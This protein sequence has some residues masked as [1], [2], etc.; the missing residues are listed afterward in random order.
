MNTKS[1]AEQTGILVLGRA[2]AMLAEAVTPLLIV[3]LLGKADVGALAGLMLIYHTLTVVLTAGFPPAVL[4]FLADR[5]A[6]TRRWIIGRM[7]IVLVGLGA[8]SSLLLIAIGTWGD[9]ALS[10]FGSWLVRGEADSTPSTV[11]LSYLVYFALFP[12]FDIPARILSNLF[13]GEGRPRSAAGYGVSQ[14]LGMSIGIGLPAAL[15]HGLKGIIF[16]L[17]CFGLLQALGMFCTIRVIYRG[18]SPTPDH[19][20]TV[21]RLFRF[22]LPLGMTDIVN[23]LNA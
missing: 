11:D 1:E 16:G 15:G 6:N 9:A 10:A 20:L 19:D 2:A 3:R 22:V 21:G 5:T 8:L 12:I 23:T 7:A 13:I 14:S 18:T 4:Y 17:T